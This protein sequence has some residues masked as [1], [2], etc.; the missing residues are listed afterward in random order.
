MNRNSTETDREGQTKAIIQ[1]LRQ[2]KRC[3]FADKPLHFCN[4]GREIL[5]PPPTEEETEGDRCFTEYNPRTSL[6][7]IGR[8]G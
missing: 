6:S 7:P 4:L 5:L 2:D 3:L 1:K 8:L